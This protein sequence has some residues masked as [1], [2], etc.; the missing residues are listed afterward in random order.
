MWYQ[1]DLSFS[2]ISFNTNRRNFNFANAAYTRLTQTRR[3]IR[4][5][6]T[7][8]RIPDPLIHEYASP[9]TQIQSRHLVKERD[10]T[11]ARTQLQ[12]L[13]WS[14]GWGYCR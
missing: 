12:H 4:S 6:F 14:G 10:T 13:A 5:N 1:V 11:Y 2:I 8:L 3:Q 7:Y 9:S